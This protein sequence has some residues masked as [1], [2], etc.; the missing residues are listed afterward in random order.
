MKEDSHTNIG[1]SLAEIEMMEKRVSEL[2][3]YLGIDEIDPESFNKQS[4]FA[5]ETFDRKA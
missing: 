5:L 4:Q 3:K 2:E 1:V